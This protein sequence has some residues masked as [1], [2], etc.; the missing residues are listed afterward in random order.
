[1][2]KA[3]MS[4]A[5]SCT[6]GVAGRGVCEEIEG[7]SEGGTAGRRMKILRVMKLMSCHWY[8][9]Y[10]YYYYHYYYYFFFFYYYYYYSDELPLLLS[11]L[12]LLLLLPLL[13]L[14][15]PLP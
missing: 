12:L 6:K 10:Y 11:I 8:Y 2:V 7:E 5:T 13:L 15:Q 14:I 4:T 3:S 1:M 9:Y